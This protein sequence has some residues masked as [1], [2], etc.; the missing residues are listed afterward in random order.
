MANFNQFGRPKSIVFTPVGSTAVTITDLV[1][2]S[3]QLD[4]ETIKH[5]GGAN[6]F[7]RECIGNDNTQIKFTTTDV[8]AFVLLQ[9]MEVTG[10]ALTFE[11]CAT[12]IAVGGSVSK[13]SGNF[14][15]EVAKT[16][17][18]MRVIEPVVMKNAA[19]GKPGQIEVTLRA[20]ILESSGAEADI[21]IDVAY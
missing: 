13:T 7:P 2:A 12:A 20:A 16:T 10:V 21:A 1:D 17:G 9:G 11:G 18:A 6:R 3:F 19:D 4:H 8:A 15:L 5:F 14:V